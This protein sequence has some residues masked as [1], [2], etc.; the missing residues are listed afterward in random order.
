MRVLVSG[1]GGFLG[2]H[3][4]DRLLQRGH[5]V[6]AIVRPA[7]TEPTWTGK[8]EIFHADLRVHDALVAAFAKH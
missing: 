2:R 5:E 7:S 6:R 1:A 8:V 3:V 4:V